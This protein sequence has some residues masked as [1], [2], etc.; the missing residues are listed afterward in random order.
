MRTSKQSA[1]EQDQNASDVAIWYVVVVSF[2]VLFVA[3]YILW[4]KCN[5]R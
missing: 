1:N 4:V 5:G 2:V 3:G